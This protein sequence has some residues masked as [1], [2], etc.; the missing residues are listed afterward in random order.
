MNHTYI[1]EWVI[2]PW[3]PLDNHPQIKIELLSTGKA[4]KSQVTFVNKGKWIYSAEQPFLPNET[5]P[6]GG[7]GG[8]TI[9]RTLWRLTEAGGKSQ[10][11]HTLSYAHASLL[12][13]GSLIGGRDPLTWTQLHIVQGAPRVQ[14]CEL[15]LMLE[16]A[17]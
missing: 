15:S 16:W 11:S 13:L 5:L 9:H 2:T 8:H 6:F 1:A 4:L 7:E 14:V 12:C 3:A 17:S 10:D